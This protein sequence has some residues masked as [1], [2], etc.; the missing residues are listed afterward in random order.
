MRK[1]T[2]VYARV[3]KNQQ[4]TRSQKP[5][6]ERYVADH[7]DELGVVKW[8]VEKHTGK[9]MDRP[10]WNRLAKAIDDNRVSRLVVW[11]LDRLGRTASGLT[12][13]FELLNAKKIR[14]V[15]LTENIDLGTSSGRMVA[16][17]IASVAA[18][19][20]EVRTERIVAG[21]AAA[22]AKGVKWGGSKKGVL[23]KITMEQVRAIVEKKAAGERIATIAK[24]TGTNR[25]DVYRILERVKQGHIQV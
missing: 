24:A 4:S 21:I 8:F 3:S 10:K 13:L 25:P 18:Y 7:A 14:F 11:K 23:H 20:N 15:S 16:N 17:I 5:M 12:K 19:E 2:A 9:I 22:K 6:L 1:F